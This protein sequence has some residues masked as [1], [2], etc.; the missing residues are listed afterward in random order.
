MKTHFISVLL[1]IA[2]AFGLSATPSNAKDPTPEQRCNYYESLA[3][4]VMS[5]RQ[6]GM[7]AVDVMANFPS[8]KFARELILQAYEAPKYST[9]E[10]MDQAATE[11]S[12]KV[13]VDC[14]RAIK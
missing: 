7:K 13:Y 6:I 12:N 14:M 10:M 3:G 5:S 1:S 9:Q 4:I 11:F 2:V 8:D